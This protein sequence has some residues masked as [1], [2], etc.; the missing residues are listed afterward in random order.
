MDNVD[1]PVI[2]ATDRDYWEAFQLAVAESGETFGKAE[3]RYA[4]GGEIKINSAAEI[5]KN[6]ALQDSLAAQGQIFKQLLMY[7]GSNRH[8]AIH[9][10]PN[11]SFDKVSIRPPNGND[12]DFNSQAKFVA[13]VQ[14]HFIKSGA[15]T[16]P[17]LTG[18]HEKFF[19]VQEAAID[20]LSKAIAHA[21]YELEQSRNRLNA[22]FEERE[23]KQ[24]KRHLDRDAEFEKRIAER[25]K[26]LDDRNAKALEEIAKQRSAV[27]AQRQELDDRNATHAR[28]QHQADIDKIFESL[29]KEFGVTKGTTDKGYFVLGVTIAAIILSSVVAGIFLYNAFDVPEGDGYLPVVKLV[30]N[31]IKAVV[32]TAVTISL[33]VFLIRWLNDWFKKHADE[34]FRLKRL[35]L[36]LKRAIWFVE[37]ARE[38]TTTK[39]GAPMP[40]EIVN[41]LLTGLFEYQAQ[42]DPNIEPKDALASMLMGGSKTRLNFPG[43]S[44][45]YDRGDMKNLN[46]GK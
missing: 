15:N 12:T 43:G 20:K 26:Q 23:K 24:Q 30:G 14:K 1:F 8:V 45:E 35:R 13:A 33:I 37:T 9:R 17:Y 2:P 36:D 27:E 21:G 19:H 22:E 44:V 11:T 16:H 34:E 5:E 6:A 32:F 31:S 3:L 39:D 18:D 4:F 40:A 29:G 46:A 7:C 42:N 41:R 28:R 10:E 25:E 38:W